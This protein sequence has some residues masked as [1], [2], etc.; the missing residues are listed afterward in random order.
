MKRRVLSLLCFALLLS[1]AGN[2]QPFKYYFSNKL[3]FLQQNND[4]VKYPFIGGITA[5]QF[6]EID[7]NFDGVKDLLVFDRSGNKVLTF[8]NANIA[9]TPSYV[10]SPQYESLFPKVSGWVLLRDYNCDGKEDIFCGSPASGIVV[11]KNVSTGK[12]LLFEHVV[13]DM[14]DIDAGNM[15]VLNLDI[16]AI[17]DIDGDGDLDILAFGVL[18]GYVQYYRNQ[19]VEEGLSCDSL[20]FKFVDF[21]WGS[22]AE[23]GL[24]NDIILGD[25]CYG[26]KFYKNQAVHS[27]STVLTFDA[28]GDGDQEMVLGDVDYPNLVY[29][30]NGK[31]EHNWPYDTV[32]SSVKHYPPAFPVDIFKFPAAF[33]V[34][35]N[36]DGKKDLIAASNEAQAAKNINQVWYYKNTGTNAIPVFEF[37]DSNFIQELTVDFGSGAAPALFDV[38][39]DGDL[40]LLIANK[41]EYTQTLNTQDRIALYENTGTATN[42]VFKLSSAD[43]M[44]FSSENILGMKP[45]FGDLDGDGK[46]DLIMGQQDGKLRHYRNTGTATAPVFALQTAALAS[47][48]IGTNAAPQLVDLDRDGDLDLVVGSGAGTISY[49][50]NTGNATAPQFSAIATVDTLGKIRVNDIYYS[51]VYNDSFEIVDSVKYFETEGFSTPY[52]TDLDNDGK[53]DLV[54]GSKSGKIFIF[55]NIERTFT[56]SFPETMNYFYD[57][58]K[59]SYGTIDLGG[60]TVPI[61]ADLNNDNIPDLLIGNF[62]GGI[63]YLSTINQPTDSVI[64]SMGEALLQMPE[65]RI[66]PNPA[67][68]VVTLLFN[69]VQEYPVFGVRVLDILGKEVY[70]GSWDAA[71]NNRFQLNS[72]AYA[73]GIYFIHLDAKGFQAKTEKLVVIR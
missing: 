16:P 35:V 12:N 33:L 54:S 58:K 25:N 72:S 21:C 68:G 13:E 22:F 63:N 32:I 67:S 28:D 70:Q 66:F 20:H 46:Q 10:Y 4:T 48:D 41:G 24:T 37:Q 7:M 44:G 51:P 42:P 18:G 1:L 53:Y 6:S 26:F 34:D 60:R 23:G 61:A 57:T 30:K 65:I 31:K 73:E 27:G 19:R 55:S 14:V 69:E 36:N 45:A 8:L 50:A 59:A 9:G 5:P 2:A 40:D 71:V 52:I 56:D 47:I 29:L 38:D 15:Y 62:R 43:W 64:T 3:P 49:F 39:G 17:T 11:Y